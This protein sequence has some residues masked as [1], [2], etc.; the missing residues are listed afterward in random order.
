MP[1]MVFP[2]V[3]ATDLD[4]T[5]LDAG[6]L[7]SERNRRAL[8]A[9][10]EAGVKVVVSTARPPR[11]TQHIAEQLPCAA[12]LCG[13]GS[14]AHVPGDEPLVRA[15]SPETARSVVEKINAELPGIGYGIETGTDFFHDADYH[16]EPWLSGEWVREVLEDT[17]TLLRRATPITK[18]L[19]RARDI[20]VEELHRTAAAAVGS[21]AEVTYSG[22]YSLLELSAPGVNKGSTL[23]MVCERWGVAAEEVVAFGDMPNDL[24]ALSWAGGGYAMASGHPDLLDPALGLRTAPPANEDGVGRVVEQLL[25]ER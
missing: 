20:P 15:I 6:G 5:L 23:A 1:T 24:A 22:S 17:E 21:L 4:G 3:I 18:L 7:V 11:T 25:A 2:R 16:L 12:V 14:L 9:A 10:A 13:N 19:V 8:A